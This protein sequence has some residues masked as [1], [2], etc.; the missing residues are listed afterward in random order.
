MTTER[1]TK[2]THTDV[3]RNLPVS[4]RKT[5]HMSLPLPPSVNSMYTLKRQLTSKARTY[6]RKAIALIN[7]YIDEQNWVMPQRET[8]LYIDMV[9]Y[10]PDKIV[11]DSHN[12]LKLLLDVMQGTVYENDYFVLPRIQSVEYDKHNPRVELC[13]NVQTQNNRQ[14]G[15]KTT[16]TNQK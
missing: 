1:I 9:F 5:L 13:V 2:V 4:S 16:L 12:M 10:M 6:Q 14:K 8:W 7:Q 3:N 15:L 11:R